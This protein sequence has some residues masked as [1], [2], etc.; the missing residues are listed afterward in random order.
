MLEQLGADVLFLLCSYLDLPSLASMATAFPQWS[1]L[2][3]RR[4]MSRLWAF[5]LR[6][7]PQYTTLECSCVDKPKP[8]SDGTL[9][10]QS[11]ISLLMGP[12]EDLERTLWKDMPFHMLNIAIV[13]ITQF[14]SSEMP[15]EMNE[16]LSK[17][18]TRQL[19][20]KFETRSE[21]RKVLQMISFEKDATIYFHELSFHTANE[22][23][24]PG[25]RLSNVKD[26]WF[27]G[28]LMPDDLSLVLESEVSRLCLNSDSLR[29]S[30]VEIV[31]NY[32]QRF[33]NGETSQ[34]SCRISASG[35]LLRYVFEGIAGRGK[36]LLSEG[37]RK[38]HL[39]DGLEETPIHCFI[40]AVMDL[41]PTE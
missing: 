27:S 9:E 17:M 11:R 41:E 1:T 37:P 16:V 5:K 4:Q 28:D 30:C 38:V 10:D 12:W 13:D 14:G 29:Q 2:I 22:A 32:I 3:Y 20:L 33:L 8:S 6:I 21:A 34:L 39:F 7:L 24:L 25:C 31:K 23:L 36:T 19:S 18:R 26:L 40:D 15:T 35:G